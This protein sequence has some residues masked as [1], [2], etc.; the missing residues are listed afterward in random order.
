MICWTWKR[1]CQAQS[2]SD[3]FVAAED[4]EIVKVVRDYGGKAMR[5]SGDFR[6]GSDR[7]AAAVR[8]REVAA[9]VNIQADEPFIEPR[10]IDDALALLE[11][12]PDFDVTTAVRVI[13]RLEEYIDPHCVK[14]VLDRNRRC[15]YFSRAPIPAQ[16][17]KTSAAELPA[18]I[19]FY[20]HIGLYSF[21]RQALE[22]FSVLPESALERCEGLEQ[23][24]WLEAGATIGA[25][26][27]HTALPAVDTPEDLLALDN[28]LT[29]LGIHYA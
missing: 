9:V 11:E 23:L 15:L 28:H 17:S 20:R 21:R 4:E 3:V 19:P 24:R 5:V 25:V 13:S 27:T 18:G 29:K 10:I 22:R 7:V 6:S 1:A 8:G 12:R 14:V 16:K 2:L 26:E